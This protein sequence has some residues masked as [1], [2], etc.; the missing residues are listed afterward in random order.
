MA[1]MDNI[2]KIKL[3]VLKEFHD[4]C[5]NDKEKAYEFFSK[6]KPNNG[7]NAVLERQIS[8]RGGFEHGWHESLKEKNRIDNDFFLTAKEALIELLKNK[9]IINEHNIKHF[10]NVKNNNIKLIDEKENENHI[11]IETFL[12][13]KDVKFKQYYPFQEDDKN[14]VRFLLSKGASL[15]VTNLSNNYDFH[16][17]T[18]NVSKEFS[19]IRNLN[20]IRN[21]LE[22]LKDECECSKKFEVILSFKE[23]KED[24]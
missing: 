23:I 13:F 2:L 20:S 1:N 22:I 17:Y 7:D 10:Y 11:S 19:I 8:F 18:F 24:K 16:G 4:S 14:N 5:L 12:D 15:G 9:I 6:K 3:D 21:I